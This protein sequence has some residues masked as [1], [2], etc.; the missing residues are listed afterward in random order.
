MK[1]VQQF[2][3]VTLYCCL[4]FATTLL[5]LKT[6]VSALQPSVWCASIDIIKMKQPQ[7]QQWIKTKH[8]RL[9]V[10]SSCTN[11][12]NHQY[13]CRGWQASQSSQVD[14]IEFFEKKQ[15][16]KQVMYRLM[17]VLRSFY[18][19][20]KSIH[21]NSI[22]RFGKAI[23]IFHLWFFILVDCMLFCS[24]AAASAT[25][26]VAA[27]FELNNS[28]KRKGKNKNNCKQFSHLTYGARTC[29]FFF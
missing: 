13:T 23:I 8:D 14:P 25:A 28:N 3:K 24:T 29:N 6:S 21:K 18:S 12:H 22:R 20:Y 15:K 19:Q 5:L 2:Q 17:Q 10:C 11:K 1:S 7:Q 26:I 27:V 16:K 9:P 4:S